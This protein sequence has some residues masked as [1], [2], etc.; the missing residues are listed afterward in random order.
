[1]P[2]G[3]SH[4]EYGA[5][6]VTHRRFRLW[7]DTADEDEEALE[8]V[9]SDGENNELVA[10]PVHSGRDTGPGGPTPW[11][12][13]RYKMPLRAKAGY[14]AMRNGWGRSL[15]RHPRIPPIVSRTRTGSSWPGGSS[16]RCT[17]PGHTID[18]LCLF[19]PEGGLMICGDHVLP[20]ITPAHLGHHHRARTR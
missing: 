19:D 14:W 4:R 8:P 10:D 6:V 1:M 17:P 13:Q 7:W 2:L 16:W 11:G 9:S 5:D 15:V 3:A 18:H 20:T 12:G